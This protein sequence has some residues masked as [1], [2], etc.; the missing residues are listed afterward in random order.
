MENKQ[1]FEKRKEAALR[2]AKK[3]GIV[4]VF[5]AS[6]NDGVSLETIELAIRLTEKHRDALYQ[7][8]EERRKSQE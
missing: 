3:Q 4:D 2:A 7:R 8:I 6:N 1:P 5:Q